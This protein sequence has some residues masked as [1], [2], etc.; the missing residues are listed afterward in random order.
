MAIESF[1]KNSFRIQKTVFNS[2]FNITNLVAERLGSIITVN[3]PSQYSDYINK[4]RVYGDTFRENYRESV[5]EGLD[6]FESLCF[7]TVKR[8]VPQS[9]R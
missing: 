3:V 2:A 8:T 7:E 5:N 1:I 4:F 9:N 6:K